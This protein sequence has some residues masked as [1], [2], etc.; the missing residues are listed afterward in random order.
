[1]SAPHRLRFYGYV[2]RSYEAVR[3]LLRSSAE[4]VM[5][6]ATSTASE[7]ANGLAARL[8]LEAAGVEVGVDVRVQVSR[9]TEE[10][11]VAGLPPVTHIGLAWK[12]VEGEGLFPS[13]SADLALSP[14]TFAETRLEFE[15]TYRPPLAGVG[16]AFD[17]V[18]GHRIAEATVHRFVNDVIEQIR[19]ELPKAS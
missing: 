4:E 15:G 19:R 6:R 3:G 17:A 9:G 12:A 8:H 7:R 11:P 18:V 16:K 10:A 2:D 14:M 5:Q 13:M 1:M